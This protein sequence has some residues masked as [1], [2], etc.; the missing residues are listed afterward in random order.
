MGGHSVTAFRL[1]MNNL[2]GFQLR[3][4]FSFA[5][6]RVWKKKLQ[7]EMVVGKETDAKTLWHTV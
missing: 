5:C 2:N 7:L 1:C 6:Q 3:G 4:K